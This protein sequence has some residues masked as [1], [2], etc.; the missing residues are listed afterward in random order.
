MNDNVFDIID[1]IKERAIA[2]NNSRTFDV[3][4]WS[5]HPEVNEFIEPIYQ[6][7]F[8]GRKGDIRKKHIKVLLLDLYVNWS[9]EPE[10][11]IAI[12][13]NN[14]DYYAASRYNALKISRLTIDVITVL[15]EAG[16][17]E[18]NE[19]F[20][21]AE[22]KSGRVTRIRP[23]EPLIRMFQEARFGPL[24]IG[25]PDDRETVVLR[26][27]DPEDSRATDVEYEDTD[28][29][30]RMAGMLARYNALLRSTFIDIPTLEG[31][32]IKPKAGGE[33]KRCFL[34]PHHRAKFIR[35]IFNRESFEMGGRFYGGWWQSC[36]KEWRSKIFIN[37]KPTSE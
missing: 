8:F 20:Y 17:I 19:G 25:Y 27:R 23:T 2:L 12:S 33:D 7:Y 16:L 28:E 13:Q 22:R 31:P 10:R 21:D 29:T 36:P 1:E 15:A 6:K 32:E 5:E 37:D 30:R 4:T 26:T 3:H 9:E 24:D 35:R 34:S 14:N 11:Y 18:Y